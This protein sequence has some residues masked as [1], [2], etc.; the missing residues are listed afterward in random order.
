[1]TQRRDIPKSM[2]K[3]YEKRAESRASAVKAMCQE[4]CGYERDAVKNCADD[5]CPLYFFRPYQEKGE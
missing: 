3:T 4:C 2:L 1:M 5:G